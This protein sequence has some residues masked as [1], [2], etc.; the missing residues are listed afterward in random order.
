TISFVSIPKVTYISKKKKLFDIPDNKRK[1]HINIIPNLGGLGIFFAFFISCSFFINPLLFDKWN[2]V[3]T[4][5]FILFLTGL[6]DDLVGMS[7]SRKF[8]AQFVASAITVIFADIRI[9]SLHGIFG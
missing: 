3:A 6:Q 9:S 7:P 8:L 1:I 4:S 5:A 2:Y